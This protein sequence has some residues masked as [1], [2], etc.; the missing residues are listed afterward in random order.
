V[1][2]FSATF[3]RLLEICGFPYSRNVGQ[4]IQVMMQGGVKAGKSFGGNEL[5][6]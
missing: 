5:S 3:L 2:F 1:R 6:P 4:V